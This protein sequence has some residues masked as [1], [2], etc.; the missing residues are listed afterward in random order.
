MMKTVRWMIG[1]G[2]I[3]ISAGLWAAEAVQPM[4]ARHGGKAGDVQTGSFLVTNILPSE[5][6]VAMS[7]A[8]LPNSGDAIQLSQGNRLALEGPA[9]FR[10]KAGESRSIN[11]RVTFP[12][13]FDKPAA[14]AIFLVLRTAGDALSTPIMNRLLPIY[15][16]PLGTKSVSFKLDLE[17]PNIR[18]V[19]ATGEVQGPKHVEVSLLLRNS[20]GDALRPRGRVDFRKE[21]KSL[22]V[23]SL[24]GAVTIPPNGTAPCHGMTHRTDWPSGAYEANVI[25]E[26]GDHYGQPQTLQKTYSFHVSGEIISVQ[27]GSSPPQKVTP[28]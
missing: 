21:N 6:D 19:N 18:F 2:A 25:L 7:P 5:M 10:L 11:Y 27:P 1:W 12:T 8:E 23:L 4:E 20:G 9:A 3:F 14:G 17:Q 15:L 13:P 28:R 16:H 24:Q 22:E 26:Y